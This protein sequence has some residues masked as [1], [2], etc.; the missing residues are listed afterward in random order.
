[1]SNTITGERWRKQRRVLDRVYRYT[2]GPVAAAVAFAVLGSRVTIWHI[3][4]ILGIGV[5]L[6]LTLPVM[7]MLFRALVLKQEPPLFQPVTGPSGEKA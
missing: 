1:M 3:L 7:E 2:A 5:P 6:R 4:I